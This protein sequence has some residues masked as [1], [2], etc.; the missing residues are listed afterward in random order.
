MTDRSPRRHT[1]VLTVHEDQD[2]MVPHH[3][4]VLLKEALQKDD[5]PLSFY[6]VPGGIHGKFNDPNVP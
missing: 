5:V 1:P 3:Q 6:T 4:S 2:P